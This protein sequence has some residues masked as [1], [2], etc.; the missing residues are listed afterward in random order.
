VNVDVTGLSDPA[1]RDEAKAALESNLV[2][3]GHPIG[4]GGPTL[5]APL[6]KGKDHEG[7]YHSFGESLFAKS[8]THI[9]TGWEYSL[10]LVADGKTHWRA[11]AGNHPPPMLQLKEDETIESHL[12]QYSNPNADF[13]K[14][15][16]VPKYVGRVR[17][18][19][20][21]SSHSLRSSQVTAGGLR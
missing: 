6:V 17:D 14:N 7:S 13:F 10:K 5:V 18:D 1:I 15:A 21:A 4:P 9:V 8:K 2:A 16:I 12:K 11:G 3:R 19:K 20:P